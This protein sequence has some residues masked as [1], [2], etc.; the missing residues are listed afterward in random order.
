MSLFV[1]WR[2]H[3]GSQKEKFYK[4]TLWQG[5]HCTV[6]LN[7]L[8]PSQTQAVHAHEG[9]DKF[10]F[11]LEGRGKFLIG[12][13]EQE[14]AAGILVVAPAGVP[15]GVTNSGN[16]RLSLLVGIAPGFK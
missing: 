14:A 7:C 13:L 10:Y 12:D 6:G 16:E 15:H 9:A 11:V 3:A 2:Q 5:E 8:E 1:D 4:T